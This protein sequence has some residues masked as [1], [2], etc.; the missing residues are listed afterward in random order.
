MLTVVES[1]QATI[2]VEVELDGDY[3]R[4]RAS[5][6]GASVRHFTGWLGLVAALDAL[7]NGARRHAIEASGS[8][9]P[10]VGRNPCGDESNDASN[11][12]TDRSP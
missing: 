5:S 1:R 12:A 9:Q 10:D 8:E 11:R 4:G 2:R 7:I 6:R 3:L